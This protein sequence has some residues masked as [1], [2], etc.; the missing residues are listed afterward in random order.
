LHAL[1]IKDYKGDLSELA[2]YAARITPGVRKNTPVSVF[3]ASVD[4]RIK[5]KQ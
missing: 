4:A 5:G 3:L 2:G 1:G